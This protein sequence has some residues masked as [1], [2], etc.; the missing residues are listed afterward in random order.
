MKK[1]TRQP[2]ADKTEPISASADGNGEGVPGPSDKQDIPKQDTPAAT[3]PPAPDPRPN[4]TPS[5]PPLIPGFDLNAAA[6]EDDYQE[7]MA[8]DDKPA[9]IAVS[10]PN[11]AGFFRAHPVHW[12]LLRMLDV[13]N[14]P[15]RGYYLV[16]GAARKLLQLEENQDV[17]LF[18]ARLTLCFSRDIGL[19]LW[20]LRIPEPGRDNQTDE[21]GQSALRICKVA[22][23][24]WVK[25]FT[26]RNGRGYFSRPGRGIKAEPPWPPF[27]IEV[28][29]Q[30]AFEKRFITSPDDP[31]IKRLLGEE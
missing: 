8:T 7:E 26:K 20:P 11:G 16:T 21:W 31:L 2:S 4:S 10:K 13:P 1:F 9:A 27:D 15:D 22:E 23:A 19:F 14:G 18:P 3:P 24:G 5:E 25:L 28:A 30:M 29:A 12:R 6:L 17:K